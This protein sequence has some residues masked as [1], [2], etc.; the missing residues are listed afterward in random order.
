MPYIVTGHLVLVQNEAG[1][2]TYHYMGATLPD[3]V[4]QERADVLLADGLI[5]PIPEAA[6][7]ADPPV[8]T[9]AAP[10]KAGRGT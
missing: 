6:P 3:Y 1:Q 10:A 7:V 9:P 8:A 5:A 4:P 2:T